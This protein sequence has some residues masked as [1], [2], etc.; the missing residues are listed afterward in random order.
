MSN[1]IQG[2]DK[3]PL[4]ETLEVEINLESEG[5]K[6][7]VNVKSDE[8]VKVTEFIFLLFKSKFAALNYCCY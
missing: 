1:A 2:V 8:E 4:L 5:F 6:R 7:V 3:C